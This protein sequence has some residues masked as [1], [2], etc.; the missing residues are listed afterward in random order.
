LDEVIATRERILVDAIKMRFVPEP[1]TLQFRRPADAARAEFHYGFDEALPMIASA[2]WCRRINEHSDRIGSSCNMV[3][4]ALCG[5]GT[6]ARDEQHQSETCDPVT[7]VL[8]EAQESEQIFDMRGLKEFE[9]A[10]L[11][12]AVDGCIPSDLSTGTTAEIEEERRLLYV[13]MTRA[14]DDL[15]LIVPQ[16]FFIHGQ[17]AQGDKHVYASRTR[18][19]PA[20]LLELFEQTAWPVIAAEPAAARA[21]RQGARVDVTAGMR[22]MWQQNCEDKG[23]ILA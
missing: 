10:K 19:I 6:D 12:E 8:D 18:F 20:G 13:A 3:E 4:H 21:A 23:G 1:G 9:P 22:A 7:R 2:G 15:H 16:R 11:H 5:G 17:N 14:K